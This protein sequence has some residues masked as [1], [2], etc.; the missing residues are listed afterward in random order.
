VAL[1]RTARTLGRWVAAGTLNQPDVEDGRHAAALRNDL[2]ADGGARQCWATIRSGLSAGVQDPIDLDEKPQS[3]QQ[4][5]SCS[6]GPDG[7]RR[8]GGRT[9][10]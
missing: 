2:V 6:I 5:S 9:T 8:I 7:P 10:R 1:N 3:P 4:A